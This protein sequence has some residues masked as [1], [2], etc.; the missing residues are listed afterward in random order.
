MARPDN[1]HGMR[2]SRPD[3][4]IVI[5]TLP[6]LPIRRLL[7]IL[8]FVASGSGCVVST[9]TVVPEADATFDERLLGAWAEV[10]GSDTAVVARGAGTAY[11]ISYTTEDGTGRFAARLG[12]L[13]DRVVLDAWPTPKERELPGAYTA[14]LVA[15]HVVVAVD[16]SGD[17]LRIALLE[18]DSLRK[19]LEAGSTRLPWTIERNRVVL[20]G[21]TAELRAALGPWVARPGAFDKGSTFRR[22]GPGTPAR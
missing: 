7:L 1:G 20:R 3:S 17:S 9:E 6:L 2:A 10:K 19:A 13:G 15:A 5:M 12:R 8:A 14:T 11:T 18:A 21:T 22:I 16:V 4:T